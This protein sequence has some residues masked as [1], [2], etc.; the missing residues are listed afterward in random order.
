MTETFLEE[1][2][3]L[4]NKY[5]LEERSDTPDYILAEYMFNCLQ[6]FEKAT[7]SRQAWHG[8]D[9]SSPETAEE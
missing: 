9:Q 6:V 1:L 3:Y 8:M 5:N 2:K 4:I 7:E